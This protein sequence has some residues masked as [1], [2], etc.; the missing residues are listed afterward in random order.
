[1]KKACKIN[2]KRAVQTVKKVFTKK[3]RRTSQENVKFFPI[4]SG[5]LK[6]RQPVAIQK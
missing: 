2:G 5:H 1:L 3:V 6:N 4:T